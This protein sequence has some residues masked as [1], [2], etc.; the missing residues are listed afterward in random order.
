[1]RSSPM[2][3][4]TSYSFPTLFY[5][6]IMIFNHKPL[7]NGGQI[8]QGTISEVKSMK[9][10]WGYVSYGVVQKGTDFICHDVTEALCPIIS[11]H[12]KE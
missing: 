8:T 11:S 2:P 3:P 12:A 9:V 7:K 4:P 1:M 6:A 10:Y 5:V